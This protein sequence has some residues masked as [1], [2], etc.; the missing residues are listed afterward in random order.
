MIQDLKNQLN[1]MS[2]REKILVTLGVIITSGILFW[3]FV[4]DPL[5]NKTIQLERQLSSYQQEHKYIQ[6]LQQKIQ[7]ARQ[8]QK[9][10][11]KK[12]TI[13]QSPSRFI[14]SLLRRYHLKKSLKSMRGTTTI[15]ITLKNINMSAFSHFLDSLEKHPRLSILKLEIQPLKA[16][17]KVNTLLM[18]SKSK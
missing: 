17:G 16:A 14:E 10:K 12:Q 5:Q 6:R 7:I 18:L 2:I 15:S 11:P 9:T 8:Q 1:T 13:R 3:A 4:L